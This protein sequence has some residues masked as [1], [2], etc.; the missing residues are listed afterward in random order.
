[1]QFTM[2]ATM[3]FRNAVY[4]AVYNANTPSANHADTCASPSHFR[5]PRSA[6]QATMDLCAKEVTRCSYATRVQMQVA[7]PRHF[8]SPSPVRTLAP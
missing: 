5:V 8:K 2:Q 6:I 1:M 7:A 4:N 3:H